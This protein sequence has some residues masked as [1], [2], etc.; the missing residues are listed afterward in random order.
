MWPNYKIKDLGFV[1]YCI[2]KTRPG[3]L[4]FDFLQVAI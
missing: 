3:F 2:E 1:T 4:G